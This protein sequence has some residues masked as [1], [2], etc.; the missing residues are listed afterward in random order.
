VIVKKMLQLEEVSEAYLN[1]DCSDAVSEA[2]LDAYE[3]SSRNKQQAPFQQ[4]ERLRHLL[5]TLSPKLCA[6]LRSSI[7][8]I[9][10][11]QAGLSSKTTHLRAESGYEGIGNDL[12]LLDEEEEAKLLGNLPDRL[13]EVGDELYPLVLTF[14]KLLLMLNASLRSPFTFGSQVNVGTSSKRSRHLS[15]ARK[16][17]RPGAPVNHVYDD[18]EDDD[19]DE[20]EIGANVSEEVQRI[21]SHGAIT[22]RVGGQ[23]GSGVLDIQGSLVNADKGDVDFDRFEGLYWLSLD[24]KHRHGNQASLVWTEIQST[25]KGGLDALKTVRGKISQ[26]E[27]LKISET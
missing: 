18:D 23:S 25:I 22:S 19:N 13:T 6:A 10:A 4:G 21:Q 26:Q 3:G 16:V 20:D 2:C 12:L 11:T 14:R 8:K 24:A 27:Y 7:S 1:T 9:K 5:V 15:A 17:G